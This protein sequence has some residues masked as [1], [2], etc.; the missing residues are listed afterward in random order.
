MVCPT[1]GI[2]WQGLHAY[3]LEPQTAYAVEDPMEVGLVYY[4]PRYSRLSAFCLHLHTFKGL[5]KP[6][7]EFAPHHYS[8]EH[9]GTS[10]GP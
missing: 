2:L 4:L 1:L 8:V 10:A 7:G 5:S 9:P 6:L 3:E